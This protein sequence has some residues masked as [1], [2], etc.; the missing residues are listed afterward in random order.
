M[1][2]RWIMHLL[3]IA[4][5]VLLVC[6]TPPFVLGSDFQTPAIS[7]KALQDRQRKEHDLLVIDLRDPAEFRVAHVPGSM[8]LPEPELAQQIQK[9]TGKNGV[10]LYCIAGKR[11]KLAEQTLMDHEI[12]NVF[13]LEGGLMGWIGGGLPVEKG[14]MRQPTEVDG[15]MSSP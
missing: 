5:C 10:V 9:L 6:L 13:H 8:N 12:P 11:T 7:A 15:S 1:P 4:I 2:H 14:A 3:P